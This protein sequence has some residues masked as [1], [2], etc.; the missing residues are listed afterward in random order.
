M[1]KANDDKNQ[2][3]TKDQLEPMAQVSELK[4]EIVSGVQYFFIISDLQGNNALH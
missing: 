1:F 4:T 2:R 3:I